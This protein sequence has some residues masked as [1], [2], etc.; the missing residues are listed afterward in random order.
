MGKYPRQF[1]GAAQVRELEARCV[2][3]GTPSAALMQ[4]AG[5]A[6]WRELL[7]RWP[8][9]HRI[10]VLCGPGNNGGDGYV[11]AQ[12]AADAG[13]AVEVWRVGAP[14]RRGDAVAARGEWLDG[15]A[16]REYR[17]E[18]LLADVVVDAIFGIGLARPPEGA[19]SSA[20]AAINAARAAGAGVLALDVPSGLDADTGA[21]PG[22]AVRADLTVTFIAAK[23]GLHTGQGPDLAGRVVLDGLGVDAA[24]TA[25]IAAIESLNEDT[26]RALLPRRART[27]HKGHMGHV[28]LIGGE[29]GMAGAI[30][31][32]ARAALRAGAG[33]VSVATREAHAAALTAAQPEIMCHGLEEPRQLRRLA[34]AASVVAIGP[35]LGRGE[36]GGAVWSQS[37]T[38]AQPLVVDADGLNWLADNRSARPDWVLTP[39]PGEAARLLESRSPDVQRDR[40]AAARELRTRC[41]GT[42]VLKG[43]GTLVQGEALALCAHGNPGMASGGMGDVLCGLIAGLR[44]QG[45]SAADAARAGVAAHSL[46]ADR[47][48]GGGERGLLPSD[49]IAQLRGVLNP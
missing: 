44:A 45:L 32:A 28:L 19:S 31:L 34:E 13:C 4:R 40:F 5:A 6:A 15:G 17:D 39:H 35:G 14:P 2:E 43:A 49:V 16:E 48:A 29:H 10:A 24:D 27:A 11:L 37:L 25:G 20:I 9:A 47:A 38:L 18:A 42:I 3:A 30:L 12:I 46:A 23:T 41:G 22:A 36:W 1:Y 33:L 21:A 26:L 7:R 8:R